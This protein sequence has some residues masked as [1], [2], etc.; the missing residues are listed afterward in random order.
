MAI[1][2][3]KLKKAPTPQ[4]LEYKYAP[5]TVTAEQIKQAAASPG[6]VERVERMLAQQQHALAHLRFPDGRS[7]CRAIDPLDVTY[8]GRSLRWCLAIDTAVQRHDDRYF[9]LTSAQRAAVSAHWSAELR[10]KVAASAE[11]DRN[12]VRIDLQDEP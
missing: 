9:T 12:E 6:L 11:R 8:D 7:W 5:V 2:F 10:A 3:S 1:D 4:H